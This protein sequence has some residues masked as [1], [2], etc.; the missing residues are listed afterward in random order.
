MPLEWREMERNTEQSTPLRF[1][2]SITAGQPGYLLL[3]VEDARCHRSGIVLPKVL[4]GGPMLE[5]VSRN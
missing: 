3:S 1:D 5:Q 4:F 2:N